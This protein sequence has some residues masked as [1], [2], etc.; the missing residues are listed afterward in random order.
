MDRKT[1]SER[2]S[3]AVDPETYRL[4]Q[5]LCLEE[6]RS[7]VAQLRMLIEREHDRVFGERR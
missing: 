3:L 7:K 5:E 1:T 4:L 6:R 2:K